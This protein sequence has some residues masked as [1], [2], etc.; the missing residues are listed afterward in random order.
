MTQRSSRG[1][2]KRAR[3]GRMD[4]EATFSVPD[5][6]QERIKDR[7]Y[8]LFDDDFQPSTKA[9]KD[10]ILESFEAVDSYFKRPSKVNEILTKKLGFIDGMHYLV[11]ILLSELTADQGASLSEAILED[12]RPLVAEFCDECKVKID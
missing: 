11:T 10:W 7:I 3:Q 8:T 5:A 2:H 4:L 1:A 6:K 12:L 9:I